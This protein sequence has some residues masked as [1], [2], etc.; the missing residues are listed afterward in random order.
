MPD[1]LCNVHVVLMRSASTVD[2][3]R[4]CRWPHPASDSCGARVWKRMEKMMKIAVWILSALLAVAFLVAGGGKL[5]T[6]A[7]ELQQMAHGVPVVLM[8]LAGAAEVL[9]ALGLVLPAAT[10]IMPVLTPVAAIGLV[11]TMVAAT[12]TNFVSGQPGSAVLTIVLGI[13]AA[14]VA[15]A[16]FGPYAVESRSNVQHAAI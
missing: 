6:P 12:I 4:H 5:L 8:K 2:A 3:E 15:F 11:V 1:N 16:R 10:R 9:G 14:I 7:G 13:L